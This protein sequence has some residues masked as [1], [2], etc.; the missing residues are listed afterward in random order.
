MPKRKKPPVRF[1]KIG[2]QRGLGN[3]AVHLR[4]LNKSQDANSSGTRAVVSHF[5]VRWSNLD[6]LGSAKKRCLVQLVGM[7]AQSCLGRGLWPGGPSPFSAAGGGPTR[8]KSRGPIQAGAPPNSPRGSRGHKARFG[9]AIRRQLAGC[10]EKS[11]ELRTQWD[12]VA[13]N[14]QCAQHSLVPHAHPEPSGGRCQRSRCAVRR[15]GGQRPTPCWG[16]GRQAGIAKRKCHASESVQACSQL[17]QLEKM[18]MDTG[19]QVQVPMRTD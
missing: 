11:N 9:K 19:K 14:E 8:R 7:A 13:K 12:R 10:F 1:N 16:T 18:W 17:D 2:F 5:R 3:R 15:E 6:F 4:S